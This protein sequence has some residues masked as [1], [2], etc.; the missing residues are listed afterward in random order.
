MSD[1][2][3]LTDQQ[4]FRPFS[5]MD[6]RS[7]FNPPWWY[8]CWWVCIALNAFV[9]VDLALEFLDI[10]PEFNTVPVN[11]AALLLLIPVIVHS[12]RKIW[13][14][15]AETRARAA[16]RMA[17]H[18]PDS[19]GYC[20]ACQPLSMWPCFIFD[21]YLDMEKFSRPGWGERLWRRLPWGRS[22]ERAVD[23]MDN[24]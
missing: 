7:K 17:V 10:V 4:L 12:T 2:D 19:L 1:D 14:Y 11:L 15:N 16:E 13:R 3:D 23:D 21:L 9:L 24:P 20:T 5:V 18:Q 22:P 8:A 6:P